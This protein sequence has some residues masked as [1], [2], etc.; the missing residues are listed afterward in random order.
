[1]GVSLILSTV[2]VMSNSSSFSLSPSRVEMCG[3]CWPLRNVLTIIRIIGV[4]SGLDQ[5]RSGGWQDWWL[6]I[7]NISDSVE[8]S[9]RF[10]ILQSVI[11]AV[12]I[13]P[14]LYL[15]NVQK[16]SRDKQLVGRSS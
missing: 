13:A 11:P 9:A 10:V 7:T 3:T 2:M 5:P 6:V 4:S 16:K 14:N 1:M 8:Q 15:A 12:C